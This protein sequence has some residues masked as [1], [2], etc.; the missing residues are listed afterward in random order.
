MLE[1]S[2]ASTTAQHPA[3]QPLNLSPCPKAVALLES[4]KSALNWLPASLPDAT[5]DDTLAQHFGKGS[6][7]KDPP[8]S[9]DDIFETIVN[10][11]LD[12]VLGSNF[13]NHEITAMLRGGPLGL[14]AVYEWLHTVI[15]V[16]GISYLLLEGRINRLIDAIERLPS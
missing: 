6:L 4:L 11:T 10:P 12:R 7:P 5:A 8:T 16:Y 2:P 15:H 1:P 9:T 13:K 3:P 14:D